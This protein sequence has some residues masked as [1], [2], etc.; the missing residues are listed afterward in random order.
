[1]FLIKKLW[2]LNHL[3]STSG[4]SDEDFTNTANRLLDDLVNALDPRWCRV[5]VD[6]S[7]GGI[8]IIVPAEHGTP[9]CILMTSNDYKYW[10]YNVD[11][12]HSLY[13]VE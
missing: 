4:H 6:F 8:G 11:N 9:R 12:F 1:M 2:S 3:N 7:S 13:L 10:R 5:E